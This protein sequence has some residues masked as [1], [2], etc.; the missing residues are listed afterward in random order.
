MM[1][2]RG[3]KSRGLRDNEKKTR[4]TAGSSQ[5]AD[6]HLELDIATA[7]AQQQAAAQVSASTFAMLP[8]DNRTAL[9]CAQ[10]NDNHK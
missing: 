1:C 3:L 6:E 9:T 5:N 2:F 8:T 4:R 10:A 7:E